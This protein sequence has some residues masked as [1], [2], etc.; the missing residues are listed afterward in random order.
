MN[1]D[2]I[3]K[4]CPNAF[5]E[6][7]KY[8]KIKGEPTRVRYIE[9][10]SHIEIIIDDRFVHFIYFRKL[11]DFFDS[12]GIRISIL[13]YLRHH[14]KYDMM[15]GKDFKEYDIFW[16]TREQAEYV[17]F[18]SAFEILEQQISTLKSS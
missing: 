4:E 5:T 3:V 14:Y 9:S 6:L 10:Q 12:V 15:V 16:D 2:K 18:E 1:I 13:Y 17:A 11:Y 7:L 8:Y